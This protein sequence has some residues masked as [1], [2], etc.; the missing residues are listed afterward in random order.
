MCV[1]VCVCVC[2]MYTNNIAS[3]TYNIRM[4]RYFMNVL[5]LSVV[6]DITKSV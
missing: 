6:D 2:D 3:K 5:T 1:C 4:Y